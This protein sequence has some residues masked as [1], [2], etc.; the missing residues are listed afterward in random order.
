MSSF[1]R[2]TTTSSPHKSSNAQGT[3][4][5]QTNSQIQFTSTGVPSLDDILGGGIQLGTDVLLLNPDPHSSHATLVQKYCISQGL[6]SG[7]KVHVFDSD[8]ED[9]VASCM[10]K[11]EAEPSSNSIPNQTSNEDEDPSTGEDKVKIAWRYERMD[12][13]R[14]TVSSNSSINDDY[15]EAF[16]LSCKVPYS[17]IKSSTVSG[18]LVY[19]DVFDEECPY[20]TMASRIKDVLASAYDQPPSSGGGVTRLIL[21]SFA[22]PSWGEPSSQK[23]ISFLLRLRSLLRKYPLSCAVLDLPSH[24]SSSSHEDPSWTDKLSW[25]S[26]ACISL[27][28]SSSDPSMAVM[29]PSHHGLVRILRLPT[30]QTLVPISDRSSTLRGISA[31]SSSGNSGGVGENNLAFKCTRRRL[32]FETFHL[33]VEGGVGERRTTPATTVAVGNEH[34]ENKQALPLLQGDRS[35]A[36]VQVE[37]IN[38]PIPESPSVASKEPAKETKEG[39]KRQKVRRKVGFQTDKPD[40]YDF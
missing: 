9:L 15:C 2:K 34:S 26:D 14:T 12:K 40:I 5:S 22:G 16:D 7:H 27:E 36:N 29:L 21:P 10:W 17:I 20:E 33:D 31:S 25:V 35:A 1:K 37:I 39:A 3:R 38:N 4:I 13:F 32:V 23:I 30:F 6:A 11:Q 19:Y 8:A 28:A 24:L 18:N